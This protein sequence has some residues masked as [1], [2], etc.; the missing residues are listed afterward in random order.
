MNIRQIREDHGETQFDLSVATKL[1]TA[2]ICRLEKGVIKNPG[3]F[4]LKKIADHY[5][6]SV[7]D[8]IVAEKE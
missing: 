8:L 2:Y 3:V 1:Q 6:V 7:D 4:T 5:G